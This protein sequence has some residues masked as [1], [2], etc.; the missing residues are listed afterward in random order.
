MFIYNKFKMPP[1]KKNINNIHEEYLLQQEKYEKKYGKDTTIVLMQV[2][3]FHEAYA[4]DTRG[5]KLSEIATLL[6]IVV[7]RKDKSIMEIDEKNPYMMGFPT[8]ALQKFLKIL[9]SEGFT[10]IVIDQISPPPDPKRA[11]TG[12]YSAGTYIEESFSPDSNNII[13]LYIE[14][15]TQMNG[16]LLTCIGMSVIDLSTGECSVYEAYSFNH[17]DKYALDEAV[18]FINSY[19][20]K[21]II[22]SRNEKANKK[23][24]S[25]DELL[26]YLELES[27]KVH[28]CDKIPAHLIK[29]SYINEYLSKIYKDTGLLSTLEYLDLE[30]YGYATV[31][32]MIVLDFAHQHD[33]N[34]I[35][36]MYKPSIFQN[37][38]HLILGNNA[39]CQLNVLDTNYDAN[40]NKNVKFKSLFNVVNNTS[41]AIGRRYLKKMLI[42]PLISPAELNNSYDCIEEIINNDIIEQLEINLKEICDLERFNRKLSLGVIHPYDFVSLYESYKETVILI[43]TITDIKPKNIKNIKKL[44]PD[45]KILGLLTEFIKEFEDTFVISEM[46]KYGLTNIEGSFFQKGFYPDIDKLQVNVNDGIALLENICSVLSGFITDDN[47]KVVGKGNKTG[48]GKNN[49]D[50]DNKIKLD[51]NNRD[52]Y[53]LKLTKLRANVLKK[54]LANVQEIEITETLKINP[55]DLEFKDLETKKKTGTTKIFFE[56]LTTNSDNIV[57]TQTDIMNLMNTYCIEKYNEFYA[58]YSVMFNKITSFVAVLDYIKSNAKTSKLY[59]Y[60]KPQIIKNDNGCIRCKQIRHPIIER[61]RTDYEYVPHDI[62]LGK[63]KGENDYINGMLIYGLNSS[64]KSSLMKAIGLSL[65][66]AQAGMYVPAS[67]YKYSPYDS[68][69]ARITGN[70]NIFKGLSSFSLEMTELRAILNRTGPR[71][72][73]IGDEVCRGTEHISGNAIVAASLIKLAK[74]E[75]TFIFATHLHEIADMARIKEIPT[76]KA[77]HLTVDYD[78]EKNTLIFDRKLKPGPGEAIYGYIVAK[79][80]IQDNEFMELVQDIKNDLLNKSDKFVDEKTSKYNSQLYVTECQICG[81]SP[82]S[83]NNIGLLDTHHINHQKDCKDGFVN[84]KP[85][86]AMNNK[87]NLIVLCKDCHYKVHHDQLEI[88]GYIETASGKKIDY[89]FLS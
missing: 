16:S 62:S 53:Y 11:V 27:K 59:N 88:K 57:T 5:C 37:N 36:N 6:N 41:T 29:T 40:V 87:A 33:E 77:Y 20:P 50:N 56:K 84:N 31:S 80:I 55:K 81:K 7:T 42:A 26:T 89:K 86:L 21:E 47:N 52:G 19:S 75:S 17:D 68:L 44:V 64:G 43:K 78:K 23:K 15:E 34:I 58:K 48:K 79:Y 39:I 74:T 51:R 35:H 85:Y 1:K 73:V 14:D 9:V 82:K 83:D 70:D 18:R 71:T 46:K 28:Y 72:L 49:N 54:N 69:F 2:G 67:E 45:K 8:L 10:V 76:I 13:S 4:T 12:V 38:K 66:M 22:I 32:F 65:I 63:N 30:R 25:K 3:S 61:I 60:C 24:M